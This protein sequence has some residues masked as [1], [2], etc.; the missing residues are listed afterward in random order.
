MPG[1]LLV[2]MYNLDLDA[3][4]Y[5]YYAA[6]GLRHRGDRLCYA[7]L[8]DGKFET[9]CL[10][11]WSSEIDMP[12]ARAVLISI[13]DE[14]S[15][16]VD[17]D[18]AIA[19]DGACTPND[20]ARLFS[21]EEKLEQS[22][23]LIKS[24]K[25]KC[26]FIALSRKGCFLAFRDQL[27]VRPLVYGGYGFDG[28]ILASETAPIVL[29]GGKP[30][31]D[32]RPGEIVYG[33]EYELQFEEVSTDMKPHTCLFEYVYLARPDSILDSVNVYMFR[34]TMGE[35]LAEKHYVDVDVVVG[36]PETAIPYAIGYAEKKKARLEYGFISTIGRLRT[37]IVRTTIEDRLRLLSLKLNLVP[38]IV[39]GS[40][41]AIVD[42]SIVTGLTLKTVVHRIRV[43]EAPLE[44]HVVVACP[45]LV[46]SCPY[47]VQ[48]IDENMLLARWFEN[49]TIKKILDV[50][51]ILWLDVEDASSYLTS[52]GISPCTRCMVRP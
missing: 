19:V 39:E 8:T 37:A 1:L 29:A 21:S 24:V 20:V 17:K 38:G 3:S 45:K 50:D 14:N 26:T 25:P 5:A 31:R 49:D 18:I 46:S 44:V 22:I 15:M 10:D 2:Y 35:I 43:Q 6:L 42:D 4:K 13:G 33:D 7:A 11:P 41:V 48:S 34:R 28:L 51:S 23:K 9:G 16:Y 27:G 40:K 47:K 52:K 30:A 36:V 12:K 32:L